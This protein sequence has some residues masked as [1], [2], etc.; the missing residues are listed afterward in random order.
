VVIP[1]KNEEKS[2]GICIQKIQK[3][4]NEHHIDGEIIVADNSTDNTAEIAKGMGAKVI[5]PE[6]HGYGNAYRFGFAR[7]SGDYIVM[8]D[9]DNTYDFMDIPRLLEPLKRGE[10]DLVLGSRFKGEI[11]KGAMP[12]HHR[13]IGNPFLTWIFNRANNSNL[14]DTHSGFRAFTRDAYEKMRT[15]LRTRGM[16]F[17]SEMLEVAIKNDLRIAE[18][19]ITYYPRPEGSEPNL[20]SFLD[21][22]RHLRHILLRAPTLL[23]LIPGFILFVLGLLLVLLIWAPFNL[24]SVRLGVH[25]M[26]A[27]CLLAVV[28]YQIFFLGLFA[29]TYGV[30]HGRGK[31]DKI[32]EF[33]GKHVTLGRGATAGLAVFLAG[34]VFALKMLMNWVSSGYEDL[35]LIDQDIAAFTLLV[36]GLQ[37]IFYS[38]FLS[39]IGGV[40]EG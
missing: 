6:E 33:I 25:S 1:T 13:Y 40:S 31:R 23:F 12:W 2:I 21:G 30:H 4:F 39:V 28:G 26:I 16:E 27:G 15:D 3:V 20:N 11:K 29:K 8:G 5:V 14:S 18:V 7:A 24:W 17:A 38:F 35:P 37:T 32:T 36:I 22:W 10:A 34:F 19:P 9:G